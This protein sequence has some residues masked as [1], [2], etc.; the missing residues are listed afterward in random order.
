MKRTLI[1]MAAIAALT[2]LAMSAAYATA[3]DA[4]AVKAAAKP[5]PRGLFSVRADTPPGAGEVRA[6]VDALNKAFADFKAEHTKH[7][8]EVRKGTADALQALS[9]IHI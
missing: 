7:L 1:S 6:A 2:S 8:D 4:V 5:V 9:L 3:V